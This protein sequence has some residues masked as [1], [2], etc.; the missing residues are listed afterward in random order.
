MPAL[1]CQGRLAQGA[2]LLPVPGRLRTH[3]VGGERP[4]GFI[5][6]SRRGPGQE[7]RE[8][9]AVLPSA[10]GRWPSRAAACEGRKGRAALIHTHAD[11]HP[12]PAVC[13]AVF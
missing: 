10:G 7:T 12:E 8:C 11:I 3:S 5:N 6:I 4:A 9:S 1:R 13:Q 2:L